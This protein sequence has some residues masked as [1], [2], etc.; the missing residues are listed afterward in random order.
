MQIH[1]TYTNTTCKYIR[2]YIC[3]S[4][5]EDQNRTELANSLGV[6]N[7]PVAV[8]SSLSLDQSVSTRSVQHPAPEALST[9]EQSIM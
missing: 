2:I 7:D 8:A 3:S 9:L 5:H 4:L 1:P 6:H